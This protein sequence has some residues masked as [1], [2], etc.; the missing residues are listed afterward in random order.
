MRDAIAHKRFR[1]EGLEC[2]WLLSANPLEASLGLAAMATQNEV[3]TSPVTAPTAPGA[4]LPLPFDITDGTNDAAD[5]SS[6]S[7]SDRLSTLVQQAADRVSQYLQHST[8]EEL[9][10]IFSG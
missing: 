10:S 7:V 3:S 6:A 2:R 9:L 4:Q 5:P 1:L 8:A